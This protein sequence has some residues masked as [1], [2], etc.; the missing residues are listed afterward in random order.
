MKQNPSNQNHIAI[1]LALSV[2]SSWMDRQILQ[3]E[4]SEP[5]INSC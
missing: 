5:L 2:I 1:N 4:G 3:Q